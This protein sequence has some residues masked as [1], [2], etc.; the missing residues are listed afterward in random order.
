MFL[1]YNE[2]IKLYFII[3]GVLG[4]MPL[5]D[6]DSVQ[7]REARM[8]RKFKLELFTGRLTKFSI[9][10]LNERRHQQNL[11]VKQYGSPVF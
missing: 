1:P 6:M 10:N 7:R 9:F 8:V 11:E 3:L 4:T 2:F 5:E